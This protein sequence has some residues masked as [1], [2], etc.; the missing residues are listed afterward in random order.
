MNI[1]QMH[2]ALTSPE[3]K[4][5]EVTHTAGLLGYVEDKGEANFF[6]LLDDTGRWLLAL[7]HNGEARSDTQHANLRRLVAAWNACDGIDTETLEGGGSTLV[8]KL[9]AM[10]RT[11]LA[12]EKSRAALLNALA[13]VCDALEAWVEIADDEDRR[14][15]DDEALA[16]ARALLG[17]PSAE[18]ASHIVPAAADPDTIDDGTG[19]PIVRPLH[20]VRDGFAYWREPAGDGV[21][22][23]CSAPINE[24]GSVLWNDAMETDEEVCEDYAEIMDSVACL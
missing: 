10:E 3:L 6:H 13:N 5:A 16:K 4:R 1:T 11:T 20:L 18:E 21:F 7:R 15:S 9:E 19:R 22:C 8:K 14:E 24:A 23:L 2:Q 17:T 12:G